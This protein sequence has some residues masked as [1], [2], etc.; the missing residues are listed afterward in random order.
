MYSY[1][2]LLSYKDTTFFRREDSVITVFYI[3]LGLGIG[4]GITIS[5]LSYRHYY[6]AITTLPLIHDITPRH[7]IGYACSGLACF[8]G[9]LCYYLEASFLCT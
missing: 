1:F 9:G 4:L 7:D 3:G 8:G 5:L 2:F 6:I